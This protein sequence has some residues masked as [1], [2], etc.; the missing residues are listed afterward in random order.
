MKKFSKLL[1]SVFVLAFI[2]CQGPFK[3]NEFSEP[4]PITFEFTK[5]TTP[6]SVPCFKLS[7]DSLNNYLII[8]LSPTRFI[9]DF[10]F[11]KDFGG[12]LLTSTCFSFTILRN[13]V[14]VTGENLPERENTYFGYNPWV[15]NNIGYLSDTI[16]LK[17]Q[18]PL[19]FK[20]PFYAFNKLKHGTQELELQ[21]AQSMFCS[22][23]EFKIIKLDTLRKDTNYRYVRHYASV[24]L[25]SF[26]AKFKVNVPQ[27]FKTTLYGY[28]I[29]LRNDSVYS[30][31]GMDNTIWKSS[32]P[33]V[34]WTVHYPKDEFYCSSDYQESTS[35]YDHRDTFQLFHYTPYDSITIGVWDHDNLSRD[36]Y[37]AYHKFGL[38]QFPNNKIARLSFENIKRFDIKMVK[39]YAVNR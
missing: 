10:P 25:I 2:S 8:N 31:A 15:K 3:K 27:I 38:K 1:A 5:N 29:E 26:R 37:I 16:D 39:G 22:A 33:D 4:K 28:A 30:P 21:C 32:Y 23:N 17:S 12:H 35:L 11:P 13:G 18:T 9:N 7:I 20:I 6:L 14:P 19:Q 36:D 24:P 34:Y